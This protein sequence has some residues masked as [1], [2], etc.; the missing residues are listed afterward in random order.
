V[1][2]T[3]IQHKL[4]YL[5]LYNTTQRN[6]QFYK[7]V[8]NFRCLVNISNLVGSA[9]GRQLS[10]QYGMITCLG[11]SNLVDLRVWDRLVDRRVWSTQSG[12]YMSVF[13]SGGIRSPAH[14]TAH[15]DAYEHAILHTQMSP[16]GRTH[17][18]RNMEE[19]SI[20]N[21]LNTELNPICH[22]LALLGTHHILH[23]SR[24]RVKY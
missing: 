17:E 5:Q 8:F 23:V 10:M 18:F 4:C 1:L 15:T 19:T 7:L 9:L 22:L 11:V 3:I 24:I 16:W 2:L 21:P 12:G 14:Q 6:A 13:H 20:I